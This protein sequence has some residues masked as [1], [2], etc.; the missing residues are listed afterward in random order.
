[1]A[2]THTVEKIGGTSMSR[3]GELL[4][5]VIIGRKKQYSLKNRIFV[6]SAYSGITNLLLEHKKSGQDGVYQLFRKNDPKWKA[7]L[8]G[9]LLEMQNINKG[10]AGLGL[11]VGSCDEHIAERVQGIKSC[12]NDLK[13]LCSYGHFHVEDYLPA[14]R[15][16]LASIGEYHSAFNSVEILRAKG[17]KAELADLSGWKTNESH[18]LDDKIKAVF[19]VI[20]IANTLTIATG[21]TKCREGLMQTF[22]RGYSEITFSK[23][24]TITE[25]AEGVIHKEFH[26]SSGDPNIIGVDKVSVIGEMN[27]DMA[28]QLADLGMEAIHPKAGKGME[29]KDIPIR[30]KN[31]FDPEHPGTLITTTYTPTQPKV[32]MICGRSDLI[33]LEICD[34]EMVGQFGYD[35]QIVSHLNANKISYIAKNTNA[36][37]IT[38]YLAE[39]EAKVEILF[40][41]LQQ[42][43]PKAR[44]RKIPVALVAVVGSH[45]TRGGVLAKA[46]GALAEHGIEI[47]AVNQC[48]R[49][50]NLQFIVNTEDFNKTLVTL[51]SALV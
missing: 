1:M 13:R 9:V 15:E 39:K 26:L 19:S 49:Q 45:L 35:Y 5:T 23:I 18:S 38:H 47:Q 14:V 17:I 6:V 41:D 27:F 51:H 10:F 7:A 36:N 24:A 25:A 43:F 44:M 3:F 37:T 42:A 29:L 46:S 8:D 22:D 30:V 21:Y 4:E 31:A 50:I 28:D 33:A 11:P 20:D 34:P 48:M 12:L 40:K 2:A 16:L 32:S